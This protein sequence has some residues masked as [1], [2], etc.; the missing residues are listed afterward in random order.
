[1]DLQIALPGAA[2]GIV[3]DAMVF[4]QGFVL[5]TNV[6]L[7]MLIGSA[8]RFVRLPF[9]IISVAVGLAMPLPVIITISIGLIICIVLARIFEKERL[10]KYRITISAGVGLGESI[11]I[12]SV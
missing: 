12:Y 8:A 11:A 4:S 7:G 5:P 10:N 1:L 9:S 3:T 6:I 2:F